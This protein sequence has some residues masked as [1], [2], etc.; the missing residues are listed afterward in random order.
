M[1]LLVHTVLPPLLDG[2]VASVNGGRL[3]KEISS[4]PKSLPPAA[5]C[6]FTMERFAFVAE[7]EFQEPKN[8][9]HVKGPEVL[10]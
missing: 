9:T 7:P 3:L 1:G 8:L 10:V 4:I 6:K 5:S 2:A